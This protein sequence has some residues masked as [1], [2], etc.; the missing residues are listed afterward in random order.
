MGKFT[1]LCFD[2]LYLVTPLLFDVG[3]VI[4]QN[5]LCPEG[6]VCSKNAGL[7]RTL[8]G[9]FPSQSVAGTIATGQ[10]LDS[11]RVER[12]GVRRLAT[13]HA[14][15]T[16]SVCDAR[17]SSWGSTVPSSGCIRTKSDTPA[18][19]T[20]AGVLQPMFNSPDPPFSPMAWRPRPP[21]RRWADPAVAFERPATTW[22]CLL[23]PG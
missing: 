15:R 21:V 12:T 5:S 16:G 19:R 22:L 9:G 7:T 23:P 20:P 11:S 4:L 10:L 13:S 1:G 6:R 3:L 18:G 14:L 8:T 17:N 2:L